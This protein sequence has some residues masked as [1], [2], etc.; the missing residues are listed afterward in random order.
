MSGGSGTAPT[1]GPSGP[2]SGADGRTGITVVI[3]V[4][5]GGRHFE[6]LTRHL[7]ALTARL[8]QV[9]VLVIDSGS[10]DGTPERAEAAGFRVHRIAPEEFGHGRTRNLG[11]ERARGEVVCFLT[12]D[13]LP[14][15]PDWP[16]RFA[17]AL[18]DRAVAGVYGRQ[19]P[20]DAT[21]MEMFFVALNYPPEPLR[22]AP[23]PDGHHPRPG[24]VVFSNAFS[25]VR[26]DVALEIPIP[27]EADYSED[28]IWA[29]KALKSGYAIVYEPEAEALH[30]HVYRLRGVFRRSFF[31]GRALRAAGIDRGASFA[32]SVRFLTREVVY[33]IR[34]GHIHRLPQLLPYEFLRWLGFH[35]GR[36]S[37]GRGASTVGW[38]ASGGAGGS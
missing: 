5:N 26:R 18:E 10:D 36:L 11:V 34:Q 33:F 31:V 9:E 22:Y 17:A 30:A 25:A 19:V 32:E 23:H 35:V 8:P 7:T 12:D 16:L 6:R 2:E 4:R 28:Q 38:S 37:G 21:T 27:E 29:R 24:R 14:I 20:R 13:V 3:P 1:A 15:T